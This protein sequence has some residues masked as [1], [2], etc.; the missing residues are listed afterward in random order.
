[1]GDQKF[2]KKKVFR[3]LCVFFYLVFEKKIKKIFFEK[4]WPLKLIK[5]KNGT[6]LPKK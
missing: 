4:L 3:S 2:E 1:L 5:R 6:F